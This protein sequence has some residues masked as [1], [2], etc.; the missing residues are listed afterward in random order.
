MEYRVAVAESDDDRRKE[1]AFTGIGLTSR[2]NLCIHPE[3]R[4]SLLSD[5][6]APSDR[7]RGR[8]PRRKRARSSTRAAAISR[9]PPS[10]SARGTTR[11]PSRHV[12]FTTCVLPSSRSSVWVARRPER[13]P[14]QNL[15]DMEAGQLIPPGIWTLADV[16][17]NGRDKGVCPYFTV[18]RMVR[19]PT[20]ASGFSPSHC[21]ARL[22]RCRSSTS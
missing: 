9:T 16:L 14:L 19:P 18:R 4:P 21:I 12:A 1:Q 2:K 7:P 6:R 22:R 3:V 17:Q 5:R 11:A 13:A 20:P 10:A 8:S 15:G